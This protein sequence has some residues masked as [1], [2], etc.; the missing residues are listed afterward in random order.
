MYLVPLNLK[1]CIALDWDTLQGLKTDIHFQVNHSSLEFS[2]AS[3][4]KSLFEITTN[5]PSEQSSDLE[6]SLPTMSVFPGEK[7][8]FFL[9]KTKNAFRKYF[10]SIF[11]MT[12]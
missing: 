4:M 5:S 8:L 10:P 9:R 1:G 6:C 3:T 7:N 12:S 11:N 2:G